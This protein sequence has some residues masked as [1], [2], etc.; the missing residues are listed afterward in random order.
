[1]PL[2]ILVVDD[3]DPFRRYLRSAL[4][5]DIEFKIIG[6]A[7]DGLEAVQQ[8]VAL[9][10][11]LVLLD[12]GLP[13]LSGLEATRQIR[14]L[15][16][17]AKILIISQESSFDVIEAALRL[18]VLGY[19]HKLHA[20]REL[21]PA[22]EAVSREAYFVSSALKENSRAPDHGPPAR[23]EVQFYS[24]DALLLEGFADF[25]ATQLQAG[26][27]VIMAATEPHRAGVLQR[28]NARSVAVDQAIASGT[29]IVLDAM[30]T[31]SKFMNG[32]VFDPDRFF[33]VIGELIE[34]AG[35]VAPRVAVCGEIAPQLLAAGKTA[36]ALR[37]EQLWDVAVHGFGCDTL[38]GYSLEGID[39]GS[40]TFRSLCAEHSAAYSQ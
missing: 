7:A 29:L 33:E 22:L 28:L 30:D 16:P 6:E 10:P 23:H 32:E 9:Q 35:K 38:C 19:V 15:V 4:K 37:L 39:K 1:M 11:D 34:T 18:G 36:Q 13:K 24:G 20:G 2:R 21:L 17:S 26:K 14:A 5:Q 40:E 3:F 8:A 12:M 25:A 31:L 27:A